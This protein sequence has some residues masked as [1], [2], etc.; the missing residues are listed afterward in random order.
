MRNF[1]SAMRWIGTSLCCLS[2]ACLLLDSG[3]T[4]AG[5]EKDNHTCRNTGEKGCKGTGDQ[6]CLASDEN[7]PCSTDECFYCDSSNK[8][9]IG[10]CVFL[11]GGSCELGGPQVD[12]SASSTFVAPKCRD[13][14]GPFQGC[15]CRDVVEQDGEDNKCE[16]RKYD[17]CDV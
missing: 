14:F 11:E 5:V 16:N 10:M 12:C 8:S 17:T 2:I 4:L 9:T 13:P 6:R 15:E 1:P 3:V 7:G